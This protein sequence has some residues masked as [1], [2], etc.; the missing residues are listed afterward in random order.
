MSTPIE[1]IRDAVDSRKLLGELGASRITGSG[2]IRSTC[3]I[4]LGDNPSAFVFSE[5]NKMW[6]CHTGCQS[7]GDCFDL[8]MQVDECSFMEA[9]HKLAKMFKVNVDWD[10][11]TIEENYFRGEAQA[12]IE[13][14]MKRNK[15]TDL[16]AFKLPPM[17]L[18]KITSFRGYT[19][20]TIDWWK[21]RFCDEGE[22]QDRIMIPFEDVDGRLVGITGRATLPNQV[23]KFLH[24]PRNLHT[25]FFLTG[26]GRNLKAGHVERAGYSVK[27]V[28][29]VF[30]C[31][32]WTD[33]GFP[34]V[35]AP[36]GVFFTDEHM[37]QLY[38]AGVL[39][40]E[41]GFDGD[42]AGRNGMR[43]AY[44]KAKG[45]FEVFFLD[46]PKGKDAD[47][48][49]IEE[50]QEVHANKLLPHEW[51]AKYGKDLEKAPKKGG[52]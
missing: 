44:E 8:V 1:R 40:L 22:L 48:C 26:L 35:C 50:L 19:Q 38:K 39:R 20:E 37:I 47:D 21:F 45:K 13:Q 41:L 29:G 12:F 11:E 17:K 30:D 36:I 34:S 5:S 16:P 14:M 23:E 49:T 4:H 32:R 31:A 15:V 33:A 24:R 18:S 6:Y 52:K 7:G 9:V 51:F 27:I 2:N 28:E 42:L 3:P 46:Y 10:N 25:G 43:K